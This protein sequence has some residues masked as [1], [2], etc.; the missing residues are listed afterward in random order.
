MKLKL[1]EHDHKLT[2]F[3]KVLLFGLLMCLPFLDIGTRCGYVL[4]NKNAY[5]SYSNDSLVQSKI[6]VNNYQSLV[7]GETYHCDYK[8]TGT[9][10]YF[11]RFGFSSLSFDLYEKF[12]NMQRHDYVAFL[13]Y[14][15]SQAAIWYY[16]DN[17]TLLSVYYGDMNFDF[18]F[19]LDST[20]TN[21]SVFN[22]NWNV[23]TYTYKPSKL[24]N[25][26]DYSINKM[27]ESP[28]YNWTQSTGMYTGVN[29]MTTGL[30]ITTPLFAILITYWLFLTII[31]IILDIVLTLF[32]FMTH[33]FT[34]KKD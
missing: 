14:G 30:G 20:Y 17:D 2:N 21:N 7:D 33:L 25:V 34:S 13:F 11:G 28:L 16:Q 8:G 22:D 23:Y 3:L 19:V 26:F 12:P 6:E 31:Y 9:N 32:T 27:A 1:P 24:D 10:A 29:A 5:Q 18:S 15:T 4:L